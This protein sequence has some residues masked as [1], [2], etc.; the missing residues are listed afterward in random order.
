MVD[1][2]RITNGRRKA[3]ERIPNPLNVIHTG[4]MSNEGYNKIPILIPPNRTNQSL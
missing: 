1:I 4:P 3:L 2:N